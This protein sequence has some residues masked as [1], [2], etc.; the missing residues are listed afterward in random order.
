MPFDEMEREMDREE[1]AMGWNALILDRIVD[2]DLPVPCD[3]LEIG[4]KWREEMTGQ[5]PSVPDLASIT[6]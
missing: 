4:K 2:W 6:I 1:R 3:K 5:V